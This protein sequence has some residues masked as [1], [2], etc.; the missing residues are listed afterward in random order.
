MRDRALSARRWRGQG[1]GPALADAARER[2]DDAPRR[3]LARLCP[4]VENDLALAFLIANKVHSPIK[5]QLSSV[6]DWARCGD[7]TPLINLSTFWVIIGERPPMTGADVAVAESVVAIS[8]ELLS[9]MLVVTHP[10]RS[11]GAA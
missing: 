7:T 3:R 5:I 8:V 10:S 6:A 9:K 11:V 1:C 4:E 2:R